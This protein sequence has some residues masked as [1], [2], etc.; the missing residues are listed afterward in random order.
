MITKSISL[1]VCGW[2]EIYW[3]PRRK[4]FY[5]HS[6]KVLLRPLVLMVPLEGIGGGSSFLC[7]TGTEKVR[8]VSDK[9]QAVL[10]ALHLSI[11]F[12]KPRRRSRSTRYMWQVR[13]SLKWTRISVPLATDDQQK[14]RER[15]GDF[16]Q[17]IPPTRSVRSRPSEAPM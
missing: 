6:S 17:L 13:V 3:C 10:R 12:K 9:V 2:D 1:P 7:G 14:N 11:Y 8:F 4:S 15:K 5:Y 16:T